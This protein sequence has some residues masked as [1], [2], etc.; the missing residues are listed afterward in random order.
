MEALG[1][2][3]PLGAAPRVTVSPAATVPPHLLV[4]HHQGAPHGKP[5]FA[6]VRGVDN[7]RF[8]GVS[9]RRRNIVYIIQ[10]NNPCILTNTVYCNT[11]NV[12]FCHLVV[13]IT[14]QKFIAGS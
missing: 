10:K 2:L 11:I 7:D 3:R 5:S 1:A 12:N 13:L 14:L 8:W 9:Q 4:P 6:R